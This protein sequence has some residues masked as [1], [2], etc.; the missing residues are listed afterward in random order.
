MKQ[1]EWQHRKRPG[2]ARFYQYGENFCLRQLPFI[3]G[4]PEIVT[5]NK[6]TALRLA[7]YIFA[8]CE[9]MEKDKQ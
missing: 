5:M 8:E 7:K 4:R 6:N 1:F 2:S 3:G 9:K